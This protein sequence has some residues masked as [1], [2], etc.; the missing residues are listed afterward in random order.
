MLEPQ[1]FEQNYFVAEK[2]KKTTKEGKAM[3]AK[4]D[5]ERGRR[6][7]VTTDDF[8]KAEDINIL[9]NQ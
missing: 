1:K 3:Y 6:I 8:L 7:W 2:P 4:L 9:F 5:A